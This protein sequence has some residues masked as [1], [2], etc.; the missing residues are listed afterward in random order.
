MCVGFVEKR[1]LADARK[2][3]EPQAAECVAHR[4]DF[5]L[6]RPR[7]GGGN[8]AVRMPVRASLHWPS[9]GTRLRGPFYIAHVP[10]RARLSTLDVPV[11]QLSKTAA[12]LQERSVYREIDVSNAS[13][14]PLADGGALEISEAVQVDA[15]VHR[16]KCE[17]GSLRAALD[18]RNDGLRVSGFVYNRQIL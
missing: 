7:T 13:L 14:V 15:S 8:R 6:L 2:A 11:Q 5:A 16:R 1:I 4:Q 18:V 3:I 9:H 10:R 12:T 17:G